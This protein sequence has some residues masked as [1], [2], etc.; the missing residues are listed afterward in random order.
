MNQKNYKIIK[1]KNNKAK[2]L[3]TH[4]SYCFKNIIEFRKKLTS[5]AHKEYNNF[6]YNTSNWI[7]RSHYCRE[8]FKN[9][10]YDEPYEGWKNLIPDDKRLKYLFDRSF[11][12]SLNQ[13]T[14]TEKDLKSLCD[15]AYNRTPFEI[16]AIFNID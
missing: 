4:C 16:S 14:Y 5:F 12:F 3:I 9:Q 7:F 8:I 2:P 13:T 6:P 15:K 10:G 11:K 1:F